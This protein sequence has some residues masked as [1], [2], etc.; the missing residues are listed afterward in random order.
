M[1]VEFHPL[2][3]IE[4][5]PLTEDS[6]AVTLEVPSLVDVPNGLFVG[7]NNLGQSGASYILSNGC[8]VPTFL[9]VATV[10]APN[11]H[12]VNYV[13][14]NEAAACEWDCQAVADGNVGIGDLL[15][16]LAQWGGAGDCD[17][18]GGGAGIN[19]LLE[20]LS[21]WGPCP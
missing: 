19:D 20:L 9:N 16:L 11:M 3:V 6:A 13:L 17:F 21:N 7:S 14:G 2:R 8:G 12:L 4:V 18:D 10:G 5:T 1:S 15:A